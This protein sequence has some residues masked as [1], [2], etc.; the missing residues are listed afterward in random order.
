MRRSLLVL[1]VIA[2]PH[3]AHAQRATDE[4]LWAEVG[5]DA[6]LGRRVELGVDQ[7]LRLG[8]EAGFVETHTQLE[9]GVRLA[10]FARVGALYR[11]SVLDGEQRHR[12]AGRGDLRL[13]RGK[14]TASYRLTVQ[15]TFRPAE[16]QLVIRNRG[17]LAVDAS[18]RLAPF[19]SVELHH[20]LAPVSE[21]RELR[22]VLGAEYRL[23]RR[24]DLAGYYLFQDEANVKVPERNHVL[25][26]G[27]TFHLGALGGHDAGPTE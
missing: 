10:R 16:Q 20:Q 18:K 11:F 9:V 7:Q 21:F 15:E 12:L 13:E 19:A 27:V 6:D 8:A 25:G 4:R 1:L 14:V 24:W 5:V 17:K 3:L 23:T 22:L 2:I 26:V